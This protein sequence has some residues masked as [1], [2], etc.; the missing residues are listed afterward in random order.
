M[1]LSKKIT[2]SILLFI[3]AIIW[4]SG[5]IVS[6]MALDVNAS[7][8]L[9][10]VI[11]FSVSTI[12]VGVVFFKRLKVNLKAKNIAQ[13]VIVGVF[14]FLGFYIQIIAL[15]Y[16]TPANNAFLTATN[17]IMVPFLW[18]IISKKMPKMNVFAACVICFVGI[19][20]LSFKTGQG[21]N[22]AVGDTLTI[23][24]ALFFACQIVAT[25]IVAKKIDICVI[26]FVQFL[27][28]SILALTVFLIAGESID[29][30][31]TKDGFLSLMFLALFS[32]CLCYFLQTKAQKN[33]SSANAAIIMGTEALF[34]ALF[35]VF[36]GYDELGLPLILGGVIIMFA[37]VLAQINE[38]KSEK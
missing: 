4:G 13:S 17:V 35:S 32:T 7:P 26:V 8:E 15:Q 9:I 3:V 24:C 34:G 36:L 10:M 1:K 30:F 38:G 14:L 20:A 29:P 2:G 25:G 28:A 21:F 18:W 33:V 31:F 12:V 27:T 16:T 6:Q 23:I 19:G 37:L 5:F 11:R 22:F